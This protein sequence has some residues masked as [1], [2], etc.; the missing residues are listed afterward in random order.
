[1][2]C[3]V[4]NYLKHSCVVSKWR[5]SVLQIFFS[6]S[7]NTTKTTQNKA[8]RSL[9]PALSYYRL[10]KVEF[11][12]KTADSLLLGVLLIMLTILFQEEH[13]HFYTTKLLDPK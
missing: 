6:T 5:S 9:C 13:Y 10:Y 4:L 11:F 2:F 7:R 8:L 3:S 12:S 1:M